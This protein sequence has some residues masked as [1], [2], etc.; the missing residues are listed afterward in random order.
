[1]TQNEAI[2]ETIRMLGGIATLGNIYQNAF[3][4]EDCKWATKTPHASIRRI[5]RTTQGIY[6][7]K[8]GLYALESHRKQLEA[9]GIVEE[10]GFNKTSKVVQDFNHSY[11]QGLI[12]TIGNL[13]RF[14]TFCPNQ[15]KNKRFASGCLDDLRS[16]H[17]IPSFSYEELIHR[18]STIDVIWFNG[19][20]YY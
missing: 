13:K 2:I 1:M 17:Q 5:V 19:C 11:Y 7:I 14:Q 4:I 16:L 12:L 8:P 15:D 9:N 3:K 10:T 18:S 6:R 20:I